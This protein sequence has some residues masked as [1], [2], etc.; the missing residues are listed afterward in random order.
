MVR[1]RTNGLFAGVIAAVFVISS[2]YLY[3]KDL[4]HVATINKL[5]EQLTKLGDTHTEQLTLH[6]SQRS[7]LETQVRQ[8]ADFVQ[9]LK[10]DAEEKQLAEK[11]ARVMAV[12]AGET[13]M[14]EMKQLIEKVET[15]VQAH[16]KRLDADEEATNTKRKKRE[17]SSDRHRHPSNPNA[18]PRKRP[19]H[20]Q[21][22]RSP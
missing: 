1:D 16:E 8:L 19:H 21:R 14:Q 6:S 13:A 2:T 11:D 12:S 18:H 9:A 17:P 3:L 20:L 5:S 7:S 10:K 15:S 22:R 4:S